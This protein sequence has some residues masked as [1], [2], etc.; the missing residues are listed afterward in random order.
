MNQFLS[1]RTFILILTMPFLKYFLKSKEVIASAI[2]SQ[3]DWNLSKNDWKKK[4]SSEAFYILREEGTERAF[5][6]NLNNEKRKGVFHCA[7]CNLPLFSSDKKFDSGTGWPSFWEPIKDSVETKV[8]FKL[9]VPRTEYHCS[10]CGGHQGHV[11][12]DGPLP[13]G[14]RYCNNGLALKFI[15][16]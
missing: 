12:N 9:I 3:E 14:K 11:F 15:A 7:G 5:S 2:T 6:S 16:E 1:R 8:D 4:L 13:T 10:R